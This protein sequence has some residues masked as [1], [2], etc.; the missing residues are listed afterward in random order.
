MTYPQRT[1]Q[2]TL[3]RMCKIQL[4]LHAFTQ[5]LIGACNKPGLINTQFFKQQRI[6][7]S[8]HLLLQGGRWSGTLACQWFHYEGR[9]CLVLVV[10]GAICRVEEWV[11]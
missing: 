9:G 6:T 3:A 11:F 2:E 4:M 7:S 8:G 1:E 10:E 5:P